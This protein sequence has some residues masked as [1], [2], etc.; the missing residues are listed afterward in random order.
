MRPAKRKNLT[1]AGLLTLFLMVALLPTW[2]QSARAAQP[3]TL[4]LNGPSVIHNGDLVYETALLTDSNGQPI[5]NGWV[6]WF[7]DGQNMNMGGGFTNSTGYSVLE[8]SNWQTALGNNT[9]SVSFNGTASY[10]PSQAIEYVDVL[11]QLTTAT[12][13]YTFTPTT[14]VSSAPVVVLSA[15][16][17]STVCPTYF[18]GNGSEGVWDQSTRTCTMEGPSRG[19]FPAFCVSAS[20]ACPSPIG[21]LVIDA[22]V[23]VV[24]LD[25]RGMVISSEVD[26]YGTLVAALVNYGTIVN[27]GTIVLNTTNQLLNLPY[28]GYGIVN[29]TVGGTINNWYYI[30]NPGT[31]YNYGTL[32]NHGQFVSDLCGPCVFGTLVNDG[33]YTGSLPAPV[34]STPVSFTGGNGTADQQATAGVTVTISGAGASNATVST[35][36]QGSNAPP[37]LGSVGLNST[38]Y[39]DIMIGGASNG[40]AHVCIRG[41]S[42]SSSSSGEMEYWNGSV[43]VGASDQLVSGSS[44]PL[45]ICGDIPVSALSG[46]PIAVGSMTAVT[47]N[48]NLTTIVQSTGKT[49]NYNSQSSQLTTVSANSQTSGVSSSSPFPQAATLVWAG[50]AFVAVVFVITIGIAIVLLSKR[51]PAPKMR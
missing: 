8:V 15:S 27:H 40:T 49:T 47:G 26:N 39:Y 48:T 20:A 7:I 43:W 32:N 19:T 14:T 23:T 41:D 2:V 50:I 4:T 33:T 10:E 9:V 46:T 36:V 44:R 12:T 25:G 5:G 24:A 13:T 6:T 3:T 31:I 45:T 38:A 35:Q 16:D 34:V 42:V 1:L 37:G 18:R 29:N 11:P 28:S 30:T 22:N 21:R 17:G 51:R